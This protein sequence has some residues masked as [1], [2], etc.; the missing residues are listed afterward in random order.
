MKADVVYNRNEEPRVLLVA[1]TDE[2]RAILM[3]LEKEG[4]SLG[5][6][7]YVGTCEHD[8]QITDVAITPGVPLQKRIDEIC[9]EYYEA[10]DV[11]PF[12]II[13]QVLALET[14]YE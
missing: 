14:G 7:G 11:T 5:R 2:D 3:R 8:S 1:E 12:T 13:N 6:I 9:A 10:D 4:C